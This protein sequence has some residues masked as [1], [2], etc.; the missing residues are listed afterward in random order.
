MDMKA[1]ERLIARLVGCYD[2]GDERV[3]MSLDEF[4]EG[5][6]DEASVGGGHVDPDHPGLEVYREVLGKIRQLPRVQGVYLEAAEVPDPDDEDE[7]EM[8]VTAIRTVILTDA[9]LEEVAGWVATFRPRDV[10]EQLD[11]AIEGDRPQPGHVRLPNDV[12]QLRPKV[13]AVWVDIR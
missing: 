11:T 6:T 5:N 10:W 2:S 7:D 13:R 9:P 1:R 4:F 12:G 8:W 3:A